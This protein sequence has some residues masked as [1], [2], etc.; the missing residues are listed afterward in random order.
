ML[1]PKFIM[2]NLKEIKKLVK[3]R[4]MKVDVDELS[5]LHKARAKLLGQVEELRAERNKLSKDPSDENKKRSLEIKSELKNL[6]PQLKNIEEQ[7]QDLLWQLPNLIHPDVPPGQ[8]EK[9]NKVVRKWGEPTEF[10]FKPKGHLELGELLDIVDVK[11]AAKVSGTR[12]NYLKGDGVLLEFALVRFAFETLI[13]EGFI[14]VL[15]P[16]LIKRE[17]MRGMGYLEHGGEEDMY[18]L[19]K[20]DLVL[21]GTSEQSIGPMHM[22]EIL[23]A[24]D[25]PKRYVAFSTCFRREAGSYGRDTRGM[26]RVHQFDKVEMFSFTKPQDSDKEHEYLLGLEEKFF[27]ALRIPY[28]VVEMCSGDLGAPAARKFDLEAWMPG[29]EKYREVTSTSNTTEF[30]ARRLNIRYRVNGKTD[31]VHTLNGTAFSG[32]AIVAVLENYQQ[33]DGT[34]KVPA[35]LVP[36]VGTRVIKG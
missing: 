16:V 2:E 8:S 33:K 5:R 21:V 27:K 15:P 31:Y 26:L 28:Q 32:R 25:L 10:K 22:D 4:G 29:Q 34:V 3:E 30:Q 20:D 1:D 24:K 12:F 36:Y 6:E 18:V 14:P 7:F 11:R 17:A 9:D 23:E 35:V 13:K 19:D